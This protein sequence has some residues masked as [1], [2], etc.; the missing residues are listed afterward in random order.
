MGRSLR[1]IRRKMKAMK[2]TSQVTKAMGKAVQ[3]AQM[4]R[5]YALSAWRILQSI[6]KAKGE[7]PHP[8][9]TQRPVKKVL[10]IMFT[11]DRGLCGNLNAQMFRTATQY[12]NGLKEIEG[13]TSIDFITLGKKGHQF[14][15]RQ[16]QNVIATFP[17]LTTN[18]KYREILPMTKLALDSFSDG[19]YDH[20]VLLYTNFI[21]PLVQEATAKVLLP[22]SESDL[23]TM[24]NTITQNK[25]VSKEEIEAKA[26]ADADVTEYAL[27]PS[28][29]EVLD[30]ILPQLTQVQVYQA[31]LESIASEHS[32]RMVAMRNATENAKDIHSDLTLTYNQTRQANITAELAELSASK[33][34]LD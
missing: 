3:N 4:L 17:P 26:Q 21:S 13:F 34:A 15:T 10:A 5:R 31:V 12:L 19:T 2:S 25:R 16:N 29:E 23:R 18:P 24:V 6:A 32:A 22:F 20:V 27:E 28:P 30:V 7:E 8:F 9:T 33:A 1:D 11:S 14:L